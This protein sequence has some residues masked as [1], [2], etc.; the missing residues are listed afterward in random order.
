MD[1]DIVVLEDTVIYDNK[2]YGSCF[3]RGFVQN[4]GSLTAWNVQVTFTAYN[5]D[6]AIIDTASGF[7][8][9]LGDIPAVTNAA[10]EAVFFNTKRWNKIAK[11]LWKAEWLTRGGSTVSKEGS[12]HLPELPI[13]DLH[14]Y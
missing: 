3:L 9:D 8:A 13:P 10:F 6:D 4:A 12:I 2:S 14:H 7:P 1:A 11:I 5:A